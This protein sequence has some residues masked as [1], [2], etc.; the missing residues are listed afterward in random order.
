VNQEFFEYDPATGTF[1][2]LAEPPLF[3]P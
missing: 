2:E 1:K 3:A